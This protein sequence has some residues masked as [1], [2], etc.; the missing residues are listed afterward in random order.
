ME[1][2]VTLRILARA[3]LFAFGLAA[4]IPAAASAQTYPS[5]PVRILVGSKAGGTTD[6]MARM[7]ADQL[8]RKSGQTVIVENRPGAGGD[9]ASAAVARA[10]PDGLT[11]LVAPTGNIVINQFL[12]KDLTFDPVN[13]LVAIAPFTEAQQYIAVA[14]KVPVNDLAGLIKLAKSKPGEMTYASA[15]LGTTMHLGIVLLADAANLNL[16]HVPY[17]G[18]EAAVLDVAAGRVDMVN[19]GLRP[20][21]AHIKSGA[22][23]VV[24]VASHKKSVAMPDVQTS[25][26]AGVPQY[27]I[28]NWYGLFAPKGTSDEIVQYLNQAVTEMFSGESTKATLAAMMEGP[29]EM[30]PAEFHAYIVQEADVWKKLIEKIGVTL[31]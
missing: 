21:L 5:K 22:I 25:T 16:I 29:L 23:K 11:L 7:L 18:A 31:H 27:E 8:S 12:K 4:L 6:L 20:L 26:E 19:V 2:T 15:G 3:L 10:N 9:L 28:S 14:S 1:E 30:K 17:N 24:G 13:D